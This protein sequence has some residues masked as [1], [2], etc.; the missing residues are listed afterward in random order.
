MTFPPQC[1]YTLSN[2]VDLV[3][4]NGMHAGFYERIRHALLI[5]LRRETTK[6]YGILT[7]V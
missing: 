3:C 2:H 5:R 1:R 4:D 7:A 6:N